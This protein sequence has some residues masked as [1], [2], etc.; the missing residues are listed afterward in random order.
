MKLTPTQHEAARAAFAKL[1]REH[2]IFDAAVAAVEEALNRRAPGKETT[3]SDGTSEKPLERWSDP[4]SCSVRATRGG[5]F[6]WTNSEF[7]SWG[8]VPKVIKAH[9]EVIDEAEKHIAARDAQIVA[10]Q[11]EVARLKADQS[12]ALAAAYSSGRTDE[13][14]ALEK[15]AREYHQKLTVGRTPAPVVE[16]D[17]MDHDATAGGGK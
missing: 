16:R 2:G 7:L 4:M 14:E 17:A 13:R 15:V 3:M 6:R 9:N 1:I 12:D 5:E 8:G 11:A 10:L